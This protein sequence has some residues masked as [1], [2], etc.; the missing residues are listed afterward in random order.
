MTERPDRLSIED[1]EAIYA[2]FG[3]RGQEPGGGLPFNVRDDLRQ[4]QQAAELG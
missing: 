3:I 2:E 1:L 4:I